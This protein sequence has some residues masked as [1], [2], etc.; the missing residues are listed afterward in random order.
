MDHYSI[1]GQGITPASPASTPRSEEVKP[2]LV[3]GK[4]QEVLRFPAG[5]ASKSPLQ[6]AMRDLDAT[7]QLLA[8]RAQY[9][10]GAS[11]AAI[12]LCEGEEMVCRASAGASAP[13][14]GAYLQANSG[15]SGE[16]LRTRQ[17]LR[18]DNVERDPRVNRESCRALGIASV[19]VMPLVAEKGVVGV[20]ELFS[21]KAYVFGERDIAAL[22]RM[23]VMIHTALEH[24]EAAKRVEQAQAKEPDPVEKVPAEPS[25]AKE[26]QVSSLEKEADAT[27][28]ELPKLKPDAALALSAPQEQPAS[29]EGESK[30]VLLSERGKIGQCEACGFPISQG[31]RLCLDC[32]SRKTSVASRVEA[33]ARGQPEESV[34]TAGSVQPPLFLEQ[35]AAI[36]SGK[37]GWI[38]SHKHLLGALLVTAIG[39]LLLVWLR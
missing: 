37:S 15:L 7:L 13:E 17:V 23:G 39:A 34:E 10:T 36:D 31:R 6:M 35:Y 1:L 27:V 30:P 2:S 24:A 12:A 3:P 19:V 16:S 33:P 28:S 32:E 14:L 18:C 29:A 21:S 11:G 20:F 9:I 26:I 25:A 4:D 8:E 38:A 22:E 5:G